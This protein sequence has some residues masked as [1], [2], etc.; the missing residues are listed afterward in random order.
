M[1]QVVEASNVVSVLL[2]LQH[3]ILSISDRLVYLGVCD[4]VLCPFIIWSMSL[5]LTILKSLESVNKIGVPFCSFL[6][7]EEVEWINESVRS[8]IESG[9]IFGAA[10]VTC[11]FGGLEGK[12]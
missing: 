6:N 4:D 3:H 11:L 9:L 10:T 8:G 5:F 12:E 1:V 7:W 2:E